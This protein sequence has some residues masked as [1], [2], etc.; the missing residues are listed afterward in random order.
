MKNLWIAT[1]LILIAACSTKK[2]MP[3][4]PASPDATAKLLMG[5]NWLVTRTGTLSPFQMDNK[6]SYDWLDEMKDADDF[7]KKTLGEMATL[8][9][10]FVN[11]TLVNVTGLKDAP[12]EQKYGVVAGGE[13][14]LSTVKLEFS[15]YGTDPFGGTEKMDLTYSYPVL[16]INENTFL[17]ATP[18]SVNERK[19]VLMMEVK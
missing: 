2:T 10:K 9:I 15:Y 13:E 7:I 8:Q 11:D 17:L 6:T 4:A 14:D 3:E 18:R 1:V 19:I 16:G 12:L 5:K